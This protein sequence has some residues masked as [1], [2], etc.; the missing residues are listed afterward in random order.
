VGQ[1]AI[2]LGREQT[3]ELVGDAERILVMTPGTKFLYSIVA[4]KRA[5]R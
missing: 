2:R 4:L 3:P 1:Q 5:S